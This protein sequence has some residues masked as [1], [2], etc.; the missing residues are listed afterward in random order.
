MITSVSLLILVVLLMLGVPVP[1]AFLGSVTWIIFSGGYDPSFLLPYGFSKMNSIVILAIP[2]FIMGGGLINRSHVGDKLVSLVELFVGHIKG[3]LGIIAIVSCAVFGSITGSACATLS[4][5]G[6]IMFP[7]LENSGY[8]VGHSAAILANASVLGMLIPPSSIMILYA[9]VGQTSVL[10]CFLS[11]VIPGVML[12][13]LMSIVNVVL[14]RKNAN[15]KYA[16]KRSLAGFKTELVKRTRAGFPA[17]T[18]PFLVLG[19]IYGGFVTPTEAAALA[20]IYVLP[21]GFFVYKKLT[22]KDVILELRESVVTTGAIMLM[23]YCIMMLSRLYIM[24]GLPGQIMDVLTSITENKYMLMVMINVFMIVIGMLMD[25]V[26]AVLLSTPILLPVV[27]QLGVDPV[28]F[29]AV[30]G[31]N[32]GLGN[33]TPP[34]APLLYLSGQISGARID[35]SMRTTLYLILFAWLP[36]LVLTTYIPDLA[37]WLPRLL[38]GTRF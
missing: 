9:W 5:I 32:L 4:A 27:T 28:H 25:D 33:V 8:P 17:L 21:I 23:L 31:V 37:L 34:T 2:L 18:M 3:G 7:R 20:V 13:I 10:A 1:F 12:M 29:A 11:S 15:I 38:L 16:E 35:Q 30:V 24:E 22:V 19:G 26:S 6:S 14:L 36:T